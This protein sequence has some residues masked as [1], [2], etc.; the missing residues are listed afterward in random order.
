MNEWPASASSSNPVSVSGET[1]DDF[2]WLSQGRQILVFQTI[3]NALSA[4]PPRTEASF[5]N[6]VAAY[7]RLTEVVAAAKNASLSDDCLEKLEQSILNVG[8]VI[9]PGLKA[10][11]D[12]S[13][14]SF[15]AASFGELRKNYDDH[16]V[17]AAIKALN[18][19]LKKLELDDIGDVF[20]AIASFL[21]PVCSAVSN[22]P[23]HGVFT[24]FTSQVKSNVFMT[25]VDAYE[26]N[27][28]RPQ[29]N[30]E[31]VVHAYNAEN[32]LLSACQNGSFTHSQLL[33]YESSIDLAGGKLYPNTFSQGDHSIK[34][35]RERVFAP[36]EEKLDEEVRASAHNTLNTL[37]TFLRPETLPD[38]LKSIR[39][40]YEPFTA[41]S[42][43]APY[44]KVFV[45]FD[46]AKQIKVFKTLELIISN[47]RHYDSS[48]L[49]LAVRAI[50]NE[51]ETIES[52]VNG[53][54]SQDIVDAFIEVTK[55][56]GG[57]IAGGVQAAGV[58]SI[59]SLRDIFYGRIKASL[60]SD[61]F[62]ALESALNARLKSAH[63]AS[64]SQ[65]VE[66]SLDFLY[67]VQQSLHSAFNLHAERDKSYLD[68]PEDR[69]TKFSEVN[70]QVTEV[71]S[72]HTAG[73]QSLGVKEMI[74][75]LG[76]DQESSSPL[77]PILNS[78]VD[79]G[80]I[81]A[82]SLQDSS[83]HADLADL[84]AQSSDPATYFSSLAVNAVG[85]HQSERNDSSASN[86]REQLVA[87][88]LTEDYPYTR[89]PIILLQDR[90]N[91]SSALVLDSLSASDQINVER[92]NSQLSD[93][94]VVLFD[95]KQPS[96]NAV[97]PVD[98]SNP[99]D[100]SDAPSLTHPSGPVLSILPSS[101]SPE[102]DETDPVSLPV[103]LRRDDMASIAD[104]KKN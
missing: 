84:P 53:V 1:S 70:A 103:Q 52:A 89:D 98:S 19:H 73:R 40:F 68:M 101:S 9:A 43:D 48:T 14:S 76:D 72:G 26:S 79:T 6:V 95:L 58:G 2:T 45:G 38:A 15:R 91:Q 7:K 21:D 64:I 16:V 78:D 33:R 71:P 60:A 88:P 30:F 63:I 90:S 34:A 93:D 8:G 82:L 12:H 59:G 39:A 18:A 67:P 31:S 20:N 86:E 94:P 29:A 85:T 51:A 10:Q 27:P 55:Q 100:A 81:S 49:S 97:D 61:V 56:S 96:L 3:Q 28:Q 42:W 92:S 4:D 74:E 62:L 69:S 77:T 32:L 25:L 22:P 35:Y 83:Q 17:N 102:G 5:G 41:R 11:G 46:K 50:Q 13:L 23:L 24:G 80:D 99:H 104:E 57:T 87:T 54:F 44:L 47:T 65:L 36:L 37:L 75:N 66:T